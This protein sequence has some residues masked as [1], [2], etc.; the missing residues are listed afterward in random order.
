MLVS[1]FQRLLRRR[2]AGA[3]MLA[4]LIG[5]TPHLAAEQSGEKIKT[6]A[7][8]GNSE[9]PKIDVSLPWRVGSDKDPTKIELTPKKMPDALAPADIAAHKQRVYFERYLK[10]STDSFTN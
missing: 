8:I 9:L 6:I 3:L 7:I 4:A 1:I 2:C 10:V 5:A